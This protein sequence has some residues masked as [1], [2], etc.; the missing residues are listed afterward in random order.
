M[1]L[2]RSSNGIN[3][4]PSRIAIRGYPGKTAEIRIEL[5]AGEPPRFVLELSAEEAESLLVAMIKA[6]T[7]LDFCD[8]IA[9]PLPIR[10][11]SPPPES[12][13]R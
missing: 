13:A 7:G 8:Y 5:K 1:S 6:T 2:L 3:Y 11:G 10:P 4:T 12:D 9:Q